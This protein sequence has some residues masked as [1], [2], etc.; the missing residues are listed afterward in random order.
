[1]CVCVRV[2]FV[3]VMSVTLTVYSKSMSLRTLETRI[4]TLRK[5]GYHLYAYI[6]VLGVDLLIYNVLALV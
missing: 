3:G 1:M 5:M 2:Y 4:S 6:Y